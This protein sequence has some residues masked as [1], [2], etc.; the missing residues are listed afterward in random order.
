ML[1]E[2]PHQEHVTNIYSSICHVCVSYRKLNEITKPFEFPIPRCDDVISSV[3]AV[4]DKILSSALT[5]ARVTIKFKCAK[6][7]KNAAFFS[8]NEKNFFCVMPFGPTNVP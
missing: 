6:L 5:S 8:P 2:K 4:S 7:I 1:A 3:C